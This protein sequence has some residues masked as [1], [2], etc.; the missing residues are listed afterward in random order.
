MFEF[1]LANLAA[2]PNL[3]VVFV[4]WIRDRTAF[5]IGY[6]LVAGAVAVAFLGLWPG[7]YYLLLVGLVVAVFD[8]RLQT[9]KFFSGK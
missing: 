6:S 3:G 7:G 5:F 1:V 2:L 9:G 4:P 8:D